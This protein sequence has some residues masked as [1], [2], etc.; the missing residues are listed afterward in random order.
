MRTDI[1]AEN[2][3]M[4]RRATRFWLVSPKFNVAQTGT[5]AF[6]G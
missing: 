4:T 3:A 2:A 6:M 1:S 5:S